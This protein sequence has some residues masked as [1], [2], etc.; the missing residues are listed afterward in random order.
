M[1]A[2][3]EGFIGGLFSTKFGEA[4]SGGIPKFTSIRPGDNAC[5]IWNGP[6]FVAGTVIVSPDTFLYFVRGFV[7]RPDLIVEDVERKEE[8]QRQRIEQG[9]KDF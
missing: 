5:R 9:A 6:D 4:T 8:S 2:E 3:R 7:T 1:T